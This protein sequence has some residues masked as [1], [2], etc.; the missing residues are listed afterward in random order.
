MAKDD[1]ECVNVSYFE[2]IYIKEKMNLT[3]DNSS[4]ISSIKKMGH[5]TFGY[6]LS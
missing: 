2:R 6:P 1:K 4:I 5:R 3:A